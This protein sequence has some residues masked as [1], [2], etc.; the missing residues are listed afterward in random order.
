MTVEGRDSED[1]GVHDRREIEAALAALGPRGF[2]RMGRS[3]W[4]HIRG[5]GL[6]PV[7][8]K[9][10]DLLY[11]AIGQ[12]LEGRRSW[13][14]GVDFERHL[15]VVMRSIASNWRR[16]MGRADA[17]G[18]REV[19][20]SELWG[21]DEDADPKDLPISLQAPLASPLPDPEAALIIKE[22]LVAV[23]RRCADNEPSSSLIACWIEELDGREMRTRLG[24]T[25]RQLKTLKERI[26]RR[27]RQ[28]KDD[29]DE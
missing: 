9:A 27:A 18:A 26:R 12:T 16:T 20:F 6:D 14:K 29:D 19:R 10:H 21:P 22:K 17:A 15:R 1:G 28:V 23:L 8:Y 5:F 7:R 13:G 24:V 11:A 3:A 2:R 25:P 4:A